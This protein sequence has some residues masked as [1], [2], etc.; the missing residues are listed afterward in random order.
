MTR[1]EFEAN[2][3][4]KLTDVAFTDDIFS[5]L[6]YPINTTYDPLIATNHI[7]EK[8]ISLLPGEEWKMKNT[9]KTDAKEQQR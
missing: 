7:L 1:A 4:E 6:P 9:T 5:L 3:A 8:I 2:I